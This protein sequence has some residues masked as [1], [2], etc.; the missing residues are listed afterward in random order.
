MTPPR[1]RRHGLG[2][3]GLCLAAL[4]VATALGAPLLTP[5]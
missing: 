1:L 5:P 3:V 2:I 4:A